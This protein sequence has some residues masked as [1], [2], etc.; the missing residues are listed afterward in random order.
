MITTEDGTRYTFGASE[1]NTDFNQTIPGDQI[2]EHYG[3]QY[4]SSWHLTGIHSAGGDTVT[5]YYESYSVRHQLSTYREQFNFVTP[6]SCVPN[7]FDV[8]NEYGIMVQQLDSIKT[9][10]HTIKFTVDAVL[11]SDALSPTGAQQERRLDKITVTTP[12]GT[13]LRVFQL[14]HDYALGSRLTLK[15]VYEQDRNGVSLPPYSFTYRGPL[16]PARTSY[17]L[18]H[19]GFYNG[20]TSNTTSIPAAVGP[21]N[22]PLSGADR[23]PD[24]AYAAA[25]ALTRITYPT[26]GYN[27]FV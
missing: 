23:E 17:A 27:E 2:P 12:T 4:T 21:G 22:T 18:D 16:L 7:Q 20:K 9:A 3:D 10:A 24:S 1:T 14:E 5:F 15:N 13:V 25:G 26:G 11:R 6:S 8:I 19:W